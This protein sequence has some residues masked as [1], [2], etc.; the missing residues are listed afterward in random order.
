MYASVMIRPGSTAEDFGTKRRYGQ[1][2]GMSFG[3]F[4]VLTPLTG[5]TLSEE[6]PSEACMLDD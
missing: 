1:D 3:R 5:S 4:A 2:P 6:T